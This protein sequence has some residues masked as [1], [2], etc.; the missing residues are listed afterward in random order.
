MKRRWPAALILYSVASGAQAAPD[1]PLFIGYRNCLVI[2]TPQNVTADAAVLALA[3]G[4][5]PRKVAV[6][7]IGVWVGP[8]REGRSP[9]ERDCGRVFRSDITDAGAPTRVSHL[10][11]VSSL[12]DDYDVFF[13]L[14]APDALVLAG[15]P[16]VVASAERH[17]LVESVKA[18]LPSGWPLDRVLVRAYRYGPARGHDIVELSIGLPTFNSLEREPPIARISIHRHYLVDGKPVAFEKYDRAS[19]VQE[20]AETEAPQLTHDNWA[21][22]ETELTVGFVSFDRG[23]TWHRLIT[24]IGFEGINWNVHALREGLPLVSRRF[25]Y[26]P[27]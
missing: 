17:H 25:L 15:K 22:S 13:A 10:A 21:E 24:D 1:L 14:A 26:T 23:L 2:E 6:E 4:Q 5:P 20:R 3:A 27:H 16:V 8:A 19:G 12:P 18:S 11:R 7:D 9:G